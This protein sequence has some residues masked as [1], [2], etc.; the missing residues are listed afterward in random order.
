VIFLLCAVTAL[1]IQ[2]NSVNPKTQ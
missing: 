1:C 2:K